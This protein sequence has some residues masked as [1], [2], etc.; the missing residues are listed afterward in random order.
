MIVSTVRE[1][2]EN[3]KFSP[4]QRLKALTQLVNRTMKWEK[5]VSDDTV[6]RVLDHIY[7]QTQDRRFQRVRKRRE[8]GKG[9]RG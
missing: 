6:A 3:G 2:I 1:L 4:L 9:L 7:Q 5:P 8:N